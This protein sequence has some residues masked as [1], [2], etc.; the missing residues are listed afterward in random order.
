MRT[1]WYAFYYSVVVRRVET[2]ST[3]FRWEVQPADRLLPVHVSS[4]RFRSMQ[5]AYEAGQAW[6]ADSP[7]LPLPRIALSTTL[8]M[9]DDRAL[10]DQDEDIDPA[11]DALDED[12]IGTAAPVCPPGIG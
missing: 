3:P 11:L 7:A 5:A 8:S 10:P 4:E 9:D 12:F 1:A 6:L 2:G